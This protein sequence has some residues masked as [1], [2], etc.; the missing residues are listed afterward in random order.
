[1][2]LETIKSIREDFPIFEREQ[3]GLPFCYL[4]SAA[5]SHKPRAVIDAISQFYALEYATVHRGVYRIAQE[6]TE[7]YESCR[8]RLAR[9]LRA[10]SSSEIVFT[11]GTTDSLN[12]LANSLRRSGRIGPGCEIVVYPLEHHANLLPW[13]M[14]ADDTGAELVSMRADTSGM[15]DLEHLQGICNAKTRLVCI[16]HMSNVTGAIYPIAEISRAVRERSNAW[17]VVDGAQSA[18]HIPIDVNELACDF[19]CFSGH[20]VFGPTGVGVLWGRLELLDSLPPAAGGGHIVENVEW[21]K[22]AFGPPPQRFEP[23]T[24][25]IAQVIGLGAA[26]EYLQGID[27]AVV[28]AYESALLQKTLTSLRQIDTLRILGTPQGP[29]VSFVV[30]GVHSLDLASWLD[31]EGI[32][33]RSGNHCAQPAMRHFGVES[34]ARISLALYNTEREIE[35]AAA[36]LKRGIEMLTRTGR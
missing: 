5:S 24:P 6:A 16:S 13:Q 7:K 9:F 35:R 8:E 11:R 15:V 31:V 4:D 3:S 32:C 19:F 25:M 27:L 14:L 18:P 33:I 21:N 30:K 10:K 23:G 22:S 34:A 26:L 28:G 36:S 20:K 17:I 1:M 12:L 29:I 2:N